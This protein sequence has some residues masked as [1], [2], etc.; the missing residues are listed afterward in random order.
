MLPHPCIL[1]GP[2]TKRD[3]IR[4]GCLTPAFSGDPKEGGN[5]T[6]PLF[7]RVSPQKGR[8]NQKRPPHPCLLRGSKEGRNAT[9]P[10]HSRGAPNETG[11]NQNWLSHPCLLRG[12]K[13]GGNATSPLPLGGPQKKQDKIR[14]GSLTP[15]LSGVPTQSGTKSEF[16]VSPLPS[17][18]GNATSPVHSRGSPKKGGQKLEG[19][20]T[21]DFLNAQKRVK[22]LPHPYILGGLKT[23]RDKKR[24]GSLTLAF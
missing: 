1:R 14:S 5:A 18:C 7:S 13:E 2:K 23:K 6:S 20:H 9:S 3:K 15:A 11:Q 4:I 21:L 10:L 22:M 8:Q 24:V 17:R 19:R 16:A 12:P